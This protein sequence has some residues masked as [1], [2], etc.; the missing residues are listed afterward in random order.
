MEAKQNRKAYKQMIGALMDGLKPEDEIPD[1]FIEDPDVLN[2]HFDSTDG[3]PYPMQ[4][5]DDV[6]KAVKKIKETKRKPKMTP[7]MAEK[8]L[9]KDHRTHAK[10]HGRIPEQV[11]ELSIPQ[12]SLL[13]NLPAYTR[14]KILR[15]PNTLTEK[16]LT[17]T[18]LNEAFHVRQRKEE[19]DSV[20]VSFILDYDWGFFVAYVFP[21]KSTQHLTFFYSCECV[22]E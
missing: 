17:E 19:V 6:E 3:K 2:M 15:L 16:Q 22:Y 20:I 5:K 8:A 13:Q 1:H 14:L 21:K 18:L 9:I 7:E 12:K 11:R 4:K 10:N